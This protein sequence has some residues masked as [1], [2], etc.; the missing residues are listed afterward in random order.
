MKKKNMFLGMNT[1]RK[2]VLLLS[3]C[4]G[5]TI[6]LFYILTMELPANK[7]IT[8]LVLFLLMTAVILSV[9]FLLERMISKPLEKINNTAVKMAALDFTA[10]CD[11]HTNDE[12]GQLTNSLNA[13]SDNL[14]CALHKLEIA[15]D[16]LEK[17]AC[18]S[19]LLLA[20]RKELVDNLSHEM[21]TPLGLICA[22]TEALKDES[23]ETVRQKYIQA[24]LDAGE[25]MNAMLVS[26]LD[27]SALEAGA[28]KLVR[29]R[30]DFVELV[31]T[32]AGRLLLDISD[33][34]CRL[35]YELP[36]VKVFIEADRR[37]ME[38]VLDNLMLNAR[39]HVCP[40]GLVELKVACRDGLLY[41]SIYNQGNTI[42]EE[43]IPVLWE[44]FYRGGERK[45]QGSGLGLAIVSQVL[46]MYAVEYGVQNMPEGVRFYFS[47]PIAI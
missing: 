42:P 34:G 30:F 2:K 45:S 21:K 18:Q 11:V 20:S 39:Q 12:F 1:I 44:K 37:R 3:K 27:L 41:F 36:E 24:V 28:A 9:D 10:H 43:D 16:L 26:L 29:K 33:N 40:G 14:K 46:S 5:G 15:N 23:D 47:F 8:F 4:V 35:A 22:Y 31:E 17:D 19:R 38:Q 32:V 25:R 6:V 13:L 7:N